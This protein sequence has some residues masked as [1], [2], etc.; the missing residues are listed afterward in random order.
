MLKKIISQF[1]LYYREF[2]HL[3][4]SIFLIPI[5]NIFSNFF[6]L[7]KR[8]KIKDYNGKERNIY[9]RADNLVTHFRSNLFY[10]KEREVQLF[11]DENLQ[12]NDIFFD[13]GANIGVFSIYA[14]IKKNAKV[15]AFE[16][17]YSN[18]NLLKE[19]I[20][21][22]NLIDNIAPY[23]LAIGKDCR[24]TNLHIAD[25]TPGNAVSSISNSD[26]TKT[27]EGYNV[28]WKEGVMEITLDKIIKDLH[29]KPK[30]LKIDTDGNEKNVLLGS[31]DLI[32]SDELRFIII[33]KT[34]NKSD[35]LFCFKFLEEF[36]YSEINKSNKGNSFW[37]KDKLD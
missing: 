17:E 23:S 7:K 34:K 29:I 11:L 12:I 24:I 18:L 35:L 16:P 2:N 4:L 36:G 20:I 1:R 6:T 31:K 22:N 10:L 9:F 30:I 3:S 25:F 32:L 13:V 5:S 33:E 28:V 19:N 27:N 21:K 8:I 14:A 26:L 37:K 15:Y